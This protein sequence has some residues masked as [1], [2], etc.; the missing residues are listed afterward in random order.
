TSGGSV[1]AANVRRT[2]WASV[3][4]I[5]GGRWVTF[6]GPAR[7]LDDPAEVAAAVVAYGRRY[8]QPR[9]RDDRVVIEIEVQRMMCN[10]G[11]K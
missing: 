5:D 2:P 9:E 1:K 7:V 8:R 6:E 10:S 3:T 11:S 4:Q